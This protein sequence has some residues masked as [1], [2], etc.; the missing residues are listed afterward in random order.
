MTRIPNAASGFVTLLFTFVFLTSATPGAADQGKAKGHEKHPEKHEQKDNKR[1]SKA[2][3]SSD[4][5]G[6]K[7]QGVDRDND[8]V[9]TRAEWRG[10]DTSF[11]NRDWNRDGVLTGNEM[12]PGAVR[13]AVSRTT[14]S[15]STPG[16]A[17]PR[18]GSAADPDGPVFARLDAN[19][20]GVLTRTEWP[21]DRFSAV[22][23]NRDGVLSAYEYGVGR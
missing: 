16:T 3:K 6:V 2:K 17:P 1:A 15:P 4:E 22:D 10:N 21:D 11:A 20:D 7:F 12:K 8:G 9:I 14:L 23:F 19:H 18:A 13:P 5:S